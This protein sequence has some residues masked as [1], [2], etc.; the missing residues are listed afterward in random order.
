MLS[1]SVKPHPVQRASGIVQRVTARGLHK[2]KGLRRAVDGVDLEVGRGEIV[3]LL[4]ANGAGKTTLLHLLA[5][6]DTCDE[7]T[8]TIAGA[9][10]PTRAEV[11]ACIGFA[12][13]H[14]AVYDE[15]TVEENLRFFAQIHGVPS[16]DVRAAVERGTAFAQL[17]D[18][19]KARA[20]TLSGGMRRRLHVAIAVAHAPLVLLLDEPLV[21]IDDETCAQLVAAIGELRDRGT[22]VVWSTHDRACVDVLGARPVHMAAG[23]ITS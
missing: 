21:G 14:T 18:R 19:R 4:G 20:G 15:L 5:G 11:P 10:D 3:A 17:G 2:A 13:Q 23:R 16:N 7:G 22:A 6:L 9:E 8:V 1:T 12:P